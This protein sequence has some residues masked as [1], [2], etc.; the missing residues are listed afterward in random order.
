MAGC[1]NTA[2]IERKW[3]GEKNGFPLQPARGHPAT[4]R[5]P[6]PNICWLNDN[7]DTWFGWMFLGGFKVVFPNLEPL[8][9]VYLD[10]YP[11]QRNRWALVSHESGE[12]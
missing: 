5:P 2:E 10:S 8:S 11:P 12:H 6:P 4:H 1:K 7:A 3:S 9:C